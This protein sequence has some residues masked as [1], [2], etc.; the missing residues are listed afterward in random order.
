MIMPFGTH[1]LPSLLIAT[2]PL[3]PT[4]GVA[5]TPGGFVGTPSA[6]FLIKLIS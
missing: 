4:K 6:A 3:V 1:D 5:V 2:D